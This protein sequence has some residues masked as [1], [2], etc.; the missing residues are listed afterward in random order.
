MQD[1]LYSRFSNPPPEYGSIPKWIWNIDTEKIT[2]EEIH[3]QF[4]GFKEHDGYTGV[5]V[6]LWNNNHYM[7]DLFFEKYEMAL[8]A[9]R[10]VGLEIIIW[11]ENGFPSGHGGGII[12]SKYPE[13]T[14]KRL[15]MQ[16][17]T[18]KSGQKCSFGLP[19]G[20]MFMGAVMMDPKNFERI[21]VSAS[22]SVS[23]GSLA[24][25][26]PAG[27]EGEWQLMVFTLA[28]AE[29]CSLAFSK[30]RLIDYLSEDAVKAFIEVTHQ[31]YFDRFP[32][33]FGPVIKYAFYDEPSFWHIIESRI[34][35][36]DF[37]KKFKV[38]HGYD[39]TPLYPSLFCDIGPDTASARAALHS[40]R[41]ELYSECYI[42][43]MQKWCASHGIK[44]T[45]HMDQEEIPSPVSISGDLIKVFEHQ[46]IPGVDQ[47]FKYGRGSPAYKIVSSAASNHD[48]PAVMCEVFGA[49]GEDM[50]IEILYKEAMDQFAKGINFVVPHGT[51]YDG[52]NNVIFPP[53][54]SFRSKRFGPELPGYNDYVKKG[55]AL[56]RGGR[57]ICDIAVLY[58]IADLQAHHKFGEG[59]PYLGGNIAGHV[60]Y[61]KIGEALSL[62]IR[63]D[64]TYLHPEVLDRKC[65][66]ENGRLV[67]GNAENREEY[68]VLIFPS[69]DV[70]ELKT[71]EKLCGFAKCGGR[72]ISVGRVP[73]KSAEHGGDERVCELMAG[74]F[75]KGLCRHIESF[76]SQ[77]LVG[78]L[79]ETG[80]TFDVECGE[81]EVTG[82]NFTYIHKEIEG[83]DVYFFANSGDEPV[84]ADVVLRGNKR[85][86]LWDPH[87]REPKREADCRPNQNGTT[88]LK[89]SLGSVKSAFYVGVV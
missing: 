88:T 28:A 66:L 21:D 30:R 71:L 53:E 38:R 41:A 24:L 26:M 27:L 22:A 46:D 7:D 59:D 44:L 35:T 73:T 4:K 76:D 19:E 8:S 89:V 5:M 87:S 62:E 64:F 32:E 54:L 78:L 2:K 37:N 17:Q 60:D 86:E 77:A 67:L 69:M 6:V 33:Y 56:L 10:E 57:H 63:K 43:T 34:W 16:S 84:S 48:K 49:M 65:T 20:S 1:N 12:E 68:S 23:G 14:A 81:V 50:P 47:I 82:G 39:P 9:A 79:C 40:F 72:L 13:H 83:R 74:L 29:A 52:E 25:D 70:I 61:T 3:R 55:S 75:E 85:L 80:L 45:G 18:A 11:D 42:H 36:G 15:D 31:A 58:P 51:W